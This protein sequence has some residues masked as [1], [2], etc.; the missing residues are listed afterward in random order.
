MPSSTRRAASRSPATAAPSMRACAPTSSGRRQPE[1]LEY[2]N[3]PASVHGCGAF[4]RAFGF[5]AG[6]GGVAGGLDAGDGA[7]L[8][9]VRSVP[10]DADGAEDAALGLAPQNAAGPRWEGRRVGKGWVRRGSR[11]W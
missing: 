4:D 3:G 6:I 2:A 11:R 7:G 9:I 8:V 5:S 1:Q 10:G